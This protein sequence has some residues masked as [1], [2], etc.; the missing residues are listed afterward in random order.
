MVIVGVGSWEWE[1]L[2]DLWWVCC[3]FVDYIVMV[4]RFIWWCNCIVGDLLW[5]WVCLLLLWFLFFCLFVRWFWLVVGNCNFFFLNNCLKWDRWFLFRLRR[6][7]LFLILVSWLVVILNVL[8]MWWWWWLGGWLVGVNGMLVY[9]VVIR[10]MFLFCWVVILV[11]IWDCLRWWWCLINWWLWLVMKWCM[12]RLNILMFGFLFSMWLM[13][14]FFLFRF[15]FR[16]FVL[17]G[18]RWWCCL[19]LEDRLGW[20]CCLVVCRKVKLIFWGCVIW[21]KL[22]LIFG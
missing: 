17:K 10:L 5:Y 3:W 1:L 4:R 2:F 22:V 13:L 18:N 7:C 14:V 6:K 8:V 20:C 9:F 12:F 11:F 16:G 19:E 15:L 21:F